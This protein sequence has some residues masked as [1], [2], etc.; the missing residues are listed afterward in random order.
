MISCGMLI[1]YVWLLC[2]RCVLVGSVMSGV[3]LWFGG[4]LVIGGVSNGLFVLGVF[5]MKVNGVVCM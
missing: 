3:V 1:S 2:Y 4:L 5:V